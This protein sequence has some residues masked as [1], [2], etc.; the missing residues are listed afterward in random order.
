MTKNINHFTWYSIVE[1]TNYVQFS[2]HKRFDVGSFYVVEHR[3]DSF[4][5][6]MKQISKYSETYINE[7]V[8]EDKND[9][10]TKAFLLTI[11]KLNNV[12][13]RLEDE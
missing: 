8:F 13:K 1:D 7:S 2:S 6:L 11:E 5:S 9:A 12:K 3:A 4:K 10:E